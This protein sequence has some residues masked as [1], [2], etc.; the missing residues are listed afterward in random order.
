MRYA[1]SSKAIYKVHIMQAL[2]DMGYDNMIYGKLYKELFSKKSPYNVLEPVEY[3]SVQ[4]ALDYIRIAKGIPVMAHPS[5]Y[6]S[7]EL[8]ERL[9]QEKKIMGVEVWHPRNKPEERKKMLELAKE[10]DLLVTGGSDFHGFYTSDANP[11][12]SC[13]CM[14]EDLQKLYKAAETL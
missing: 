3:P 11:L 1:N 8:L 14:E 13:L 2:I 9:A 5:V 7:M 6:D 10:H 4:E 12:A